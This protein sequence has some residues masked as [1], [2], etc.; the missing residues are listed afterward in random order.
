M[1]RTW[2]SKSLPALRPGRGEAGQQVA[3]K[4]GGSPT[5]QRDKP[6]L[7][8]LCAAVTAPGASTREECCFCELSGTS[9]SAVH[10]RH[11]YLSAAA[12]L[13]PSAA[14]EREG[15]TLGQGCEAKSVANRSPPSSSPGKL[16]PHRLCL[17]DAHT[18][19]MNYT[20]NLS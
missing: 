7:Q 2:A 8:P 14:L 3:L 9:R 12:T 18:T 5:R 16:L 1:A 10:A 13:V 11:A 15:N 4:S 19:V 20:L 6:F 17:A